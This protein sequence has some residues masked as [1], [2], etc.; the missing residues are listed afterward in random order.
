LGRTVA[1]AALGR[2]SNA[3]LQ[4]DRLE[5]SGRLELLEHRPERALPAFRTSADLRRDAE[6]YLGKARVVALAGA[7]A[8]RAGLSADGADLYFRAGRSAE[9]GRDRANARRWLGAAPR[10]AETTGPAAILAEASERL[11]S[12]AEAEGR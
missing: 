4:A 8:E 12:L 7:A 3:E 1:L 11:E 10:L 9:V 6:D 2:S 5:L